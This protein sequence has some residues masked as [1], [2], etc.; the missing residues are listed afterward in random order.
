MEKYLTLAGKKTAADLNTFGRKIKEHLLSTIW[1]H[2][3]TTESVM[4]TVG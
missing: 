1:Q 3:T 2:L 4:D